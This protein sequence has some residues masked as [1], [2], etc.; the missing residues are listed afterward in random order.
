MENDEIKERLDDI[1]VKI[2]NHIEHDHAE[3]SNKLGVIDRRLN[4]VDT[5]IKNLKPTTS[6]F[7]AV[8]S[9]ISMIIYLAIYLLGR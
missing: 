8:V 4:I 7:V 9:G 6:R 2:D 1:L 3:I 5:D